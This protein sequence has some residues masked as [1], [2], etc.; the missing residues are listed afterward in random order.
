MTKTQTLRELLE[1][2]E[3]RCEQMLRAALEV[4]SQTGDAFEA[5]A[6]FVVR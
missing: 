1:Y 3:E 4:E 5:Q 6:R 2:P